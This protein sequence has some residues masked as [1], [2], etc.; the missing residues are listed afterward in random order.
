VYFNCICI[1]NRRMAFIK[2]VVVII[3]NTINIVY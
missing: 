2:A 1:Q 3:T